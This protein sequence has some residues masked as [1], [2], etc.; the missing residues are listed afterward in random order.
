MNGT[1]C[2]PAFGASRFSAAI[3]VYRPD[4]ALLRR[5][6]DSLAIAL[7][8][9]GLAEV[10]LYLVDNETGMSPAMQGLSALPSGLV[11]HPCCGQ[12]N[13]GFGRGHNLA[14]AHTDSRYHLI[15]NP[16][17]EL[18]PDALVGALG[19]LDAHPECGLLVPDVRWPDGSR[20]YLC[21]RY[22]CVLDLLLRSFAP[23][24]LR[25]RCRARLERYEMRDVIGEETVFDP[26][27]VSGCCMLFRTSVLKR[28]GGFDPRYFLYFED[29]DLSLRAR[30]ITHI[31]YVPS[32][33]IVHHGG[34]AA[35]KGWRHIA[36]FVRSG[37]TFFNTHGWKWW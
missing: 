20:Q 19:F 12:G 9:A 3:V 24:W 36:M 34:H 29:F 21:K 11:L 28:A 30:R 35:R 10:T 22:P 17:A 6:V 2:R 1:E 15:L 26:P 31:A 5:A 16:D 14:I 32:V 18:A 23:A 27:I 37:I 8:R 4:A 25:E 33:R 13:V 7:H